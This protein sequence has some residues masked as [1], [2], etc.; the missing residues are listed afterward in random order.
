MRYLGGKSRL[1][2]D[3]C[4]IIQKFVDNS[5]GYWEPFVGAG[6]VIQNIKHENRIGSDI[7]EDL[8]LLWQGLQNGWIPPDNISE[9]EYKLARENPNPSAYRG[10]IGFGSSWGGKWFG[11]Y[12]RGEARNFTK[13][14]KESLLRKVPNLN[15]VRFYHQDYQT[16]FPSG[17]VIYCDPPYFGTTEYNTKFNHEEFWNWARKVSATNVV[18]V[19]EF[20]APDDFEA[21]WSKEKLTDLGTSDNTKLK[22]TEKLFRLKAN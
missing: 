11:G 12:A 15:G 19:S 2:K 7:S 8:I 18:L 6:W 22:V 16:Q 13:E 21:I 14:A 17:Y 3:I 1:V 4:P 5:K 20:T 10:F 9:E